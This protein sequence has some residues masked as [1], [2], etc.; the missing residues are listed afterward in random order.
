MF[1]TTRALSA[2]GASPVQGQWKKGPTSVQEDGGGK[3][4]VKRNADLHI[5]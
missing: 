4:V 1:Y 3:K 2:S 5:K